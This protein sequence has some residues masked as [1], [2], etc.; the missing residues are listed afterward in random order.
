MKPESGYVFTV[1]NIFYSF[2]YYSFPPH[3]QKVKKAGYFSLDSIHLTAIAAKLQ[4]E[5]AFCAV[6]L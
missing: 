6:K 4:L 1:A 5:L 3:V 2:H